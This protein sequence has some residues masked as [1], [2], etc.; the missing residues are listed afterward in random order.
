MNNLNFKVANTQYI[1]KDGMFRNCYKMSIII[2]NLNTDVSITTTYYS[3]K[4]IVS[5]EELILKSLLTDYAM[6]NIFDYKGYIETLYDGEDS[7]DLRS[8][9]QL[10]TLHKNKLLNILDLK[11]IQ[12]LCKEILDIDLAS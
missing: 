2:S 1:E 8:L 5:D 4:D 11:T 6:T 10:Q 7:E 12:I 9:Y 3:S